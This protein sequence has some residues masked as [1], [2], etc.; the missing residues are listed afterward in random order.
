MDD[1]EISQRVGSILYCAKYLKLRDDE[2]TNK[3]LR[4]Y[5]EFYHKKL[6]KENL[7][8]TINECEKK[9][10]SMEMPVDSVKYDLKVKTPNV[11]KTMIKN[12]K[13]KR[14]KTGGAQNPNQVEDQVDLTIDT[15]DRDDTRN[16]ERLIKTLERNQADMQA[17]MRAIAQQ[18]ITM[19]EA[20]QLSELAKNDK[21]K[22][23]V[24]KLLKESENI[25]EN[26]L[27]GMTIY[28]VSHEN[29]PDWFRIQFGILLRQL[30]MSP[31]H[32]FLFV[33]WQIPMTIVI[34]P[35]KKAINFLGDKIEIAWGICL[36]AVIGTT[37]VSYWVGME[38]EE[39]Q[40]IISTLR[41]I[42]GVPF[43]I[44][45]DFV[46][47]I[48]KNAFKDMIK[49]LGDIYEYLRI[50]ITVFFSQTIRSAVR[51]SMP[52]M[53]NSTGW[54]PN[55]S[56]W[57]PGMPN[58]TGWMP[59]MPSMPNASAWMPGM[60]SMPNASAWMSSG[61]TDSSEPN[62]SANQL[63]NATANA[64]DTHT[65]SDFLTGLGSMAP[66]LP[67]LTVPS[68]VWSANTAPVDLQVQDEDECPA[69]RDDF[70]S[71]LEGD[72]QSAPEEQEQS[73]PE[74]QEQSAPEEQEES[75]LFGTLKRSLG[76]S[77]GK[78]TRKKKRRRRK[79]SKRKHKKVKTRKRKQGPKKKTRK[80]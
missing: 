51:D 45:V 39:K 72:T 7:I 79:K 43:D 54:M 18:L 31:L 22:E 50:G 68:G 21:L 15:R 40:R 29:L 2:L 58:T 4:Q 63:A 3:C 20:L 26:Q 71:V 44:T 8:E 75:G 49:I 34:R 36:L 74:E 78:L 30:A 42:G 41:G 80:Y 23:D 62:A 38:D 64:S 55:A 13:K 14:E 65:I 11:T 28:H 33:C 73:V 56:A 5:H 37:V 10:K 60:P 6:K 24:S 16:Q 17:Q 53:P 46:H 57:R 1:L 61:E 77:G 76:M 48:Y 59:D 69:P 35:I 47:L 67:V 27:A 9:I 70:V 32:L 25:R 66:A 52:S 19:N 12:N